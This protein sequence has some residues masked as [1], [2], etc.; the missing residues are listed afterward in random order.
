MIVYNFKMWERII[1]WEHHNHLHSKEEQ[2]FLDGL[3]EDYEEQL[4]K[5][6]NVS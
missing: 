6:K 5:E 4:E 1:R 2:E 3:K